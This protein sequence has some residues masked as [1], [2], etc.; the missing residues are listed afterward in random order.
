MSITVLKGKVYLGTA[1]PETGGGGTVN[2][3]DLYIT[4]NGVY[5]ADVGYTG[6]GTATVDIPLGEKSI[7]ENGE[8]YASS[9]GLQGYSSVT[10]DV[11]T[12]DIVTATNTTGSAI[13]EGDKV[14]LNKVSGGYELVDFYRYTGSYKLT[15]ANMVI[16][17]PNYL[18]GFD[19]NKYIQLTNAFN[20]SS[21]TW[22][23]GLK[24]YVHNVTG[25]VFQSCVGISNDNQ[26]FGILFDFYNDKFEFGIATTSSA[27]LF[28]NTG[29]H[30][31]QQYTVYWVKLGWDGEKYYLDYS[32]D[33][34]NYTRDIEYSSTTP[35]YN[36]LSYTFLGVYRYGSN[37]KPFTGGN[38][39]LAE[40]YA[41]SNGAYVWKP[42]YINKDTMTGFA[43]ENIA[44]D[45]TGEVKTILPEQ[46]TVTVTASAD[47]AEITAV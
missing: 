15:A 2:N 5:T 38:I 26:R 24:F 3:E 30:S 12:P 7:T 20:P 9:D 11:P 43:L 37:V 35:V 6:I 23:V 31:V 27:W 8:F 29:T 18:T 16:T 25:G 47:N 34:I 39:H 14:W 21:N 36:G 19:T 22:E 44:I 33:G 1:T 32:T 42:T 45:G 40:C 13:S 10:V 17:N 28:A 4:T 41:K 46:V